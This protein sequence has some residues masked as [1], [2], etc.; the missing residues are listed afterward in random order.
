MDFLYKELGSLLQG[1]TNKKLRL[2]FLKTLLKV[3]EPVFEKKQ[4]VYCWRR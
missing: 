4:K 3:L 1:R 2:E